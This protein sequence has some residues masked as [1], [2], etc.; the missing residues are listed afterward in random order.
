M[1]IVSNVAFNIGAPMGE[2]FLYLPSLGFCIAIAVLLLR[3]LKISD[4][5]NLKFNARIFIP[6]GIILVLFSYKTIARNPDW[7]N[8]TILFTADAEHSPNSAKVH[9]YYGNSFLTPH[10]GKPDSREKTEDLKTA[11]REEKI[12]VRI[13]PEFH[14]AYYNLGLI[15]QE[16][17]NGDSALFYLN[18][19]LE[20][21][22][23]HILAQGAIGSVYGKLKGDYNNAIE[24]L[25]IAVKYNPEDE[26]SWDNLGISYAMKGDFS[27]S[28]KAFTEAIKYKK[29]DPRLYLNTAITYQ[30]MKDS[31]NAKIF[32]NKAFELDPSLKQ[33]TQR[34]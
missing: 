3:F 27:E 21:Q 1:S 17:Q 31:V 22:P 6:A 28:L 7:K 10:L 23:M 25:K 12:A 4:W 30:N 18:K 19:V 15:Y 2:R 11:L 13:N 20:L 16:L 24:H 14:H 33:P 5:N 26:G 8:N 9:H 32:F 34:K 29:D